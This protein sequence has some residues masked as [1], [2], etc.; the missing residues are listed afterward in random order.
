MLVSVVVPV[1][2]VEKYLKKC[3]DSL[4]NQSY[5]D[6]EIILV[7]DGSTDN[8]YSICKNYSERDS[9]IRVFSKDNEGLGLTRN[10]GIKRAAGHYLVLVDSDDELGLDHINQLINVAKSFPKVDLVIAGYE[11]INEK[12]D[13]TDR[14]KYE[15]GHYQ[16]ST[17][18]D[19][20]LPRLIGGL[21][22]VS[23]SIA[24]S[25]CGHLYSLRL[26][27]EHDLTFESERLYISEDLI[28]NFDYILRSKEVIISEISTYKYRLTEGSLTK[29]YLPDRFS[30]V[31]VMYDYQ[32]FKL[33]EIYSGKLLD[34]VMLRLSK[35]YFI[36]LRMCFRQEDKSISG[37]KI[38]IALKDIKKICED[39]YTRKIISEYPISQLGIKQ[40][41]FIYLVKYSFSSLIYIFVKAGLIE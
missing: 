32:L 12:S 1:Y 41:S 33:T 35:Q 23:D 3:I 24:V 27:L 15:K 38:S 26:I 40:K 22:N 19:S 13:T 30:K 7:D 25:A 36:Y 20:M 8:S 17:I 4:V 39:S 14:Y 16:N 18:K 34:E 21:P 9:R 2:N 37:K 11:R 6:L 29:R 10:Y 5:R 28:F 31:K